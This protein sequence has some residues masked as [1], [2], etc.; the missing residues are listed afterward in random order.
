[1]KLKSLRE[2]HA[3]VDLGVVLMIGIAF[4]ALMVV[5]FIIYKLKDQLAPT[6]NALNSINN[7]TTG[8]DNAVNLILVAITI[9]ILAVAISALLMLRGGR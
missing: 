5:G 3:V 8:F 7:I 9:F 6:G 2:N 4:A 1:M